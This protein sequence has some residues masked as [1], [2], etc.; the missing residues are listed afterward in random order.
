MK[1]GEGK[2]PGKSWEAAIGG[3]G[4]RPHHRRTMGSRLCLPDACLEEG[5]QI[6]PAISGVCLVGAIRQVSGRQKLPYWKR[7]WTGK[8]G[9]D[10]KWD[11]PTIGS[12]RYQAGTI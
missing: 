6:K 8:E 2:E 11:R 3:A 5:S 12:I 4:D 1:K 10:G 9:F 7:K